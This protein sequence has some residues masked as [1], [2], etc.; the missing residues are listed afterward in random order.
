MWGSSGRVVWSPR[1]VGSLTKNGFLGNPVGYR[2]VK[3][4]A[5]AAAA[6]PVICQAAD[7]RYDT[8]PVLALLNRPTAAQTR[9]DL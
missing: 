8:H 9:A 5:E 1:D 2:A 7:R 6:L 4:I 3:V